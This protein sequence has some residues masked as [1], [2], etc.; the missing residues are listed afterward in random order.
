MQL[1]EPDQLTRIEDKL[2][3]IIQ[4]LKGG[5]ARKAAPIASDEVWLDGLSQ[6]PTYSGINV[7][8]EYGKC[9]NWCLANRKQPSRRRFINWLNNVERPT[10]VSSHQQVPPAYTKRVEAPATGVPMPAEVM[11]QFQK[12]IAGKGM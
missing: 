8:Q 4:L 3:E 2:D 5:T 7:R 6:D 1:F 10:M 12:L 11:E 9:V